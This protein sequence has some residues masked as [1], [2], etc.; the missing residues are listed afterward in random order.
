M[1]NSNRLN[2]KK[3]Q[4]GVVKIKADERHKTAR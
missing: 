2:W 4:K 1:K 3:D